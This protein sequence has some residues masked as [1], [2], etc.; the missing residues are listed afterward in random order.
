LEMA[1]KAEKLSPEMSAKIKAGLEKYVSTL[2]DQGGPAVDFLE[3]M[4]GPEGQREYIRTA[5]FG[6]D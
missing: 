5:M 4:V 2:L 6:L 3:K 1:Q